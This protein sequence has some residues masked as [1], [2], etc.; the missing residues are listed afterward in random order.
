MGVSYDEQ[1]ICIINHVKG[2]VS[3][4]GILVK[5]VNIKINT[6]AELFVWSQRCQIYYVVQ[7]PQ[8]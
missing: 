2:L 7:V 3:Y 6:S 5:M 8:H 1:E 4:L